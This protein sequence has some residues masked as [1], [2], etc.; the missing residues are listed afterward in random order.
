MT[1]SDFSINVSKILFL[2]KME[3]SAKISLNSDMALVFTQVKILLYIVELKAGESC[4]T[5]MS[6]SDQVGHIPGH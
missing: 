2:S 3:E 5:S 6:T 4:D 1:L